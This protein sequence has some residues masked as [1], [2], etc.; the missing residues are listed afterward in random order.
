MKLLS[1]KL[2]HLIESAVYGFTIGALHPWS[3]LL[4][5]LIPILLETLLTE[6]VRLPWEEERAW[7]GV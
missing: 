1:R 2:F 6:S 4:N 3:V 5:R 7:G